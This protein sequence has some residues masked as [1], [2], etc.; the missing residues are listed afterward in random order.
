[1]QKVK[2]VDKVRINQAW[3][4]AGV[5]FAYVTFK[6]SAVTTRSDMKTNTGPLTTEVAY[7]WNKWFAFFCGKASFK[8]L[9]TQLH[10]IFIV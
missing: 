4:T 6:V 9:F 2:T 1:M 8:R 10:D 3:A 5:R 7:P